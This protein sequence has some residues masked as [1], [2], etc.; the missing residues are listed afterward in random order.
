LAYSLTGKLV[1]LIGGSGFFGS[2]VA[3]ELLARGARLRLGSRHPEQAYRLRPLANL[4]Q[5]QFVRCDIRDAKSMAAMLAGADAAVNLVGAFSGNLDAIQGSG[6]GRVA[7][8]AA[9]AGCTS[10]VHV[11]AIGAD[12][13]SSLAYQRSKGHGEQAVRETFANATILRPSIL[14][15]EEDNFLNMF[16]RL[17]ARLPML[18]VFAPQ[19]PL[20]PLYVDDAAQAVVA[21]LED[22][23]RHG[24]RTYEI[25]G[26]ERVTM[27]ELN[28]RIAD[29]QAR[30]RHFLPLSDGMGRTIAS[31]SG[32]LP[33]VP[34][35]SDQYAMLAQ[36]NVISG[37]HPGLEALGITPRPMTLFLDR[38]MTRYR[39]YG[40]FTESEA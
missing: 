22:P 21:A 33:G 18:P 38:W 27:M 10:F 5:I 23:Y 7:A 26:P 40:R 6:A 1:A 36:G 3:Q 2:H 11:S 15:G 13:Q 12:A 16:G 17:I 4:G 24:G 25:A 8:I 31:L 29:A 20:Q 39:R 37:D 32:W 34:I 9:D 19:A 30:E 28:R 35:S 14:F